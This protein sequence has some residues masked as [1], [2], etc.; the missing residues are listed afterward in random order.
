MNS[1]QLSDKMVETIQQAEKIL[2]EGS[3]A[4]RDF[5]LKKIRI[6][7]KGIKNE[8]R[9]AHTSMGARKKLQTNL[10]LLMCS[11]NKIKN[12]GHSGRG[13]T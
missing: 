12:M 7:I 8:I 13:L 4:E 9:N 2:A 3:H 10:G 1:A 5:W 6:S 11:A